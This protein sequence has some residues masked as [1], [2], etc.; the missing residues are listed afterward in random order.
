MPVV[1]IE[2]VSCR[3]R[4]V[5][6]V[7]SG[8]HPKLLGSCLNCQGE[9]LYHWMATRA[10]GVDLPLNDETTRTGA[11]RS[12]LVIRKGVFEDHYDYYF[13]LNIT[14]NFRMEGSST[15]HLKA[16][17]P[18]SSGYCNVSVIPNNNTMATDGVEIS[19]KNWVDNANN[20]A[21]LTFHVYIKNVA[22][23]KTW[24]SVYRSPTNYMQFLTAPFEEDIGGGEVVVRV[25]VIDQQ[26]NEAMAVERCVQWQTIPPCLERCSMAK[27]LEE[28]LASV[29]C[30]AFSHKVIYSA[31]V[32]TCCSVV[33]VEVA[34]PGNVSMTDYLREDTATMLPQL[35]NQNNP[36]ELLQYILAISQLLN[37]ETS[38]Y[39]D[40][41]PGEDPELD[42]QKEERK[43]MREELLSALY[44]QT[45][46]TTLDDLVQVSYVLKLLT[47]SQNP[48]AV[49]QS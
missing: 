41:I 28:M 14:A 34:D 9:I 6:T 21:P 46:I 33:F 1:S 37:T 22:D 8:H 32:C 7:S 23:P 38:Q 25:D 44:S 45:S 36:K 49:A 39:R 4:N 40:I 42:R 29:V 20:K 17:P 35:K 3:E 11:H 10:D 47:V 27:G 2:C 31:P 5:F 13:T 48:Y 18:P 15:L 26:F 12:N 30:S 43:N 19:C 24:Y 16:S